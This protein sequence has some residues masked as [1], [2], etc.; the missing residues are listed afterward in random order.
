MTREDKLSEIKKKLQNYTP[1]H[2]GEKNIEWC[3]LKKVWVWFVIPEWTH[4]IMCFN[5][6]CI[7]DTP[8]VKPYLPSNQPIVSEFLTSPVCS[9]LPLLS[10][11][12]LNKGNT[13]HYHKIT[14][15]QVILTC[16]CSAFWFVCYELI[17]LD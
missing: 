2:D 6:L 14:Q 7:W 15:S 1:K 12:S 13:F 4:N 17:A 9:A 11:T 3:A 16:Y 10:S 5:V 8:L